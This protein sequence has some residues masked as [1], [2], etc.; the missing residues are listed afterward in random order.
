LKERKEWSKSIVWK[1][2]KE[3]KLKDLN[4]RSLEWNMNRDWSSKESREEKD[5]KSTGLNKKKEKLKD[6]LEL[7]LKD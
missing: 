1:W 2:R 5:L 7:R 4:K 6:R 3:L